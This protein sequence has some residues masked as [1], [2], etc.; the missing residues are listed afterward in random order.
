MP[1]KSRNK[2][3]IAREILERGS[4]KTIAPQRKETRML[5]ADQMPKPMENPINWITKKAAQ[6]AGTQQP[7]AANP[8]Q[9]QERFVKNNTVK[10]ISAAP[11]QKYNCHNIGWIPVSLTLWDLKGITA[12]ALK[13]IANRNPNQPNH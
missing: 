3:N 1:T 2:P 11:S 12:A 7:A 4:E 5:Q 8:H 13:K 6:F 10:L 9:V